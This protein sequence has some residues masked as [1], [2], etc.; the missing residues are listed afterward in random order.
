M[1]RPPVAVAKTP[2]SDSF[3]NGCR[4]V[5]RRVLAFFV[6]V[7]IG[8]VVLRIPGL[9]IIAAL[10]LFFFTWWSFWLMCRYQFGAGDA[11]PLLA[12]LVTASTAVVLAAYNLAA[13][14]TSKIPPRLDE[15]MVLSGVGTISLLSLAEILVLRH[16]GERLFTESVE[17]TPM[18]TASN[19][20]LASQP[21]GIPATGTYPPGQPSHPKSSARVT[22][23]RGKNHFRRRG[24]GG[25]SVGLAGAP[26][27]TTGKAVRYP[28]S[29]RSP[30]LPGR[31][32][33]L[34]KAR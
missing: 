20:P 17:A 1:G 11:N 5:L 14:H 26:Q 25:F 18:N 13:I 32:P 33:I 19:L 15:Q 7:A 12:P 34:H 3:K 31:P 23:R 2:L 9:D 6:S 22:F 27:D 24:S 29:R 8:A 30:Q 4:K 10:W 21:V 28:V 16:G